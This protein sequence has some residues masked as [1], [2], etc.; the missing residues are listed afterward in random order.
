MNNTKPGA[1][2]GVAGRELWE[3]LKPFRYRPPAFAHAVSVA[4]PGLA[5]LCLW[6]VAGWVA[7]F[8]AA[9]RLKP[10]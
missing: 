4:T 8:F 9:G 6:A 10:N 1:H 2:G 5:V 7:L 3:K